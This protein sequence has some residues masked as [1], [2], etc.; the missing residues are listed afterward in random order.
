MKHSLQANWFYACW[1]LAEQCFSSRAW[2]SPTS[3]LARIMS[4]D[5][6]YIL[7]YYGLITKQPTGPGNLFLKKEVHH[8]TGSCPFC[9][10][11]HQNLKVLATVPGVCASVCKHV[12]TLSP[13]RSMPNVG[14]KQWIQRGN[15]PASVFLSWRISLS[16]RLNSW[17]HRLLLNPGWV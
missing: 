11:V 3:Y 8:S 15:Y 17:G 9:V 12:C 7:W 13:R 6:I 10:V 14:E 5:T 4:S 16:I 2:S 1:P